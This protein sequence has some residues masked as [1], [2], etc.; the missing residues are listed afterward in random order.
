MATE[1]IKF[2]SVGG[3]VSPDYYGRSDLAKF[4]LALAECENWVVDYHGGLS[5][6]PGSEFIDYVQFD[7]YNTKFFSFKFSTDIANT[8]VILFGKNYI[9]FIQN[10]AYVT[11]ASQTI[12]AIT[13]AATGVITI[14]AH[15]YSTGNW[16]EILNPGEMV[17]MQN[18]TCE[19]VVLTVDTFQLLTPF[20]D[21][22]NTSAFTAY[23]SGGSVARVYTLVSPYD[24]KDLPYLRSNQIKDLVR[25]THKSYDTYDLIRYNTASWTFTKTVFDNT[26]TRPANLSG[27]PLTAGTAAVAFVVTQV[28]AAG[29]ESIASDFLFITT[30]TQYTSIA[31]GV[32]IK[33]DVI[34]G[35]QFY[36]IY[37]TIIIEKANYISRSYQTGFVGQS[38]GAYFVD[39]GY[40]PDFAHT[41]P[42]SNNP[43]ANG[44]IEYVDVTAGGTAY[45]NG[46][47]ITA[48]DVNPSAT[49]F[50]GAL[51]VDTSGGAAT[52]PIVGVI[53]LRGGSNYTNPVF[54]VNIGSGATFK[55]TLSPAS[56]NYPAVAAVY[57]QRQIYFALANQPLAIIGSKPGQLSNFSFSEIVV[58]SDAYNHTIDSEDFS[59][60]RHVL[61]ARGGLLM[62]N[63]AGLWLGTGQNGIISATNIQVDPQVAEGATLV[64][65]LRVATDV[66][67]CENSGGKVVQL[68][69]T[70]LSRLYAGADLSLL[71]SHLIT[72]AKQIKSWTYAHEPNRTVW[73]VRSD[74]TILA[75]T[76]I[77]QQDVYAW[78]RRVTYGTYEDIIS[79]NEEGSSTVY[80][81]TRRFVNGRY[82]KFIEKFRK[83]EFTHVEDAFC[84][85]C[86]LTYPITSPAASIDI[87][88]ISGTSVA[89]TANASVFTSL[90]VGKILRTAGGKARVATFVDGYGITVSFIRPISEYALFGETPKPNTQTVGNW[91]LDSEVTVIKGLVHLEGMKVSVLADGNVIPDLR[92]VSGSITLPKKA[93]RI[94]VGLGFTA[95]AR[96]LPLTMQGAIIESKR[97]RVLGLAIRTSKTRGLKVGN[98]L[99]KLYPIKERQHELQ[100]E[101]TDLQNGMKEIRIDPVWSEEAQTYFIQDSPLPATIIGYVVEMEAGDDEN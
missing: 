6:A 73:A 39:H 81:M 82:S 57:Q 76:I 37:R 58:D 74:G 26:A 55:A 87:A 14:V 31:G 99:D 97:K 77:K 21:S 15:G 22:L 68:S 80:V 94:I 9:R 91:T 64:P 38:K 52:G 71:A 84:V 53:T 56:G 5:T 25:F 98:T 63:A 35:A 17:E 36:N 34:P 20:G 44:S 24:E 89:V 62:W 90:D 45:T 40:L 54:T 92:V 100:G 51:I 95:K 48:S 83:Q 32:A 79:L 18:M 49:G 11:E 33:W 67:Y 8:N 10:G 66:V 88:A 46:S 4:D 1:L 70:E 47:I 27:T 19:I 60:I 72:S 12:G 13:L 3:E 43:F 78:A 2:A 96:N 42:L 101:A 61:A 16:I 75:L 69:Y 86:G 7:Q 23:S 65:P 28:D 30:C 41:P 50:V 59:P 29:K 93:S 85:D